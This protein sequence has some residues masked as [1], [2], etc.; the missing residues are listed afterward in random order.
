[1]PVSAGKSVLC[2]D[3]EHR[4]D[5]TYIRELLHRAGYDV[6]TSNNLRDALILMRVSR[7]DLVLL[8]AGVA[9]SPATEKT[10]RDTCAQLPTVELGSDFST[11]RKPGQTIA[12]AA[13]KDCSLPERCFFIG[14]QDLN[15]RP[16]VTI[17][18]QHSTPSMTRSPNMQRLTRTFLF[19]IFFGILSQAASQS[20][21]A[22]Q[23]SPDTG[24]AVVEQG[25]F[26]LH[27]F[28]QA[29]GE[30]TYEIRRQGEA[31]GV[32]MDFKFTDRGQAVPLTATFRG[33]RDLTPQAFEN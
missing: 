15:S 28:E 31:V 29:I 17:L 11:L 27:K 4:R 3:A 33:A 23:Q 16:S 10:C 20:F 26:T 5:R 24:T 18:G 19:S 7:F 6:H 9:G 8:G 22:A 25:K 14:S 32:K 2:I 1:M 12:C 21:A 30:E 13:R